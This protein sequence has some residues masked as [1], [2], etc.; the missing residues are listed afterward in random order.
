MS[1][2]KEKLMIIDGNA[3]I[4]RSF[5]ALPPTMQ[6]KDGTVVN[7][8]YGFVTTLL[9]A[10]ND[11]KPDYI[12][13]TFDEKGPTFRHLE[14]TEY[15][16]HR[17]KQ[18]DE[19][20]AQIPLIKQ[21]VEAFNIPIYSQSGLEADDLIGTI[22]HTISNEIEKI[23]LTGDMDTLQLVNDHTKVYAM[24]R[25]I[26]ES[27]I[28]DE[29]K[30]K[31]KYSGLGPDQMIDY[32]ALRGDPSDNI[33]GVKGIG[34]KTAISLLTEFK[35]LD[36]VYEYIEKS[37]E[38]KL[39][40]DK[41][42]KP[43]IIGLLK[44]DK[45]N[46]YLSQKLAT[47]KCD[48]EIDFDLKKSKF[49]K[50]N[51]EELINLLASLEFHSLIPRIKKLAEGENAEII[52]KFERN[53]KLFNYKIIEKETEFI[54]FKKEL[55]GL[56]HFTFDIESNSKNALEADIIGISFSWQADRAYYLVID[57]QNE[58]GKLKEANLFNYTQRK[59]ATINPWL[60]ELKPIFENALIQK[61]GHNIKYDINALSN[62]GINVQ[63]VYFDTRLASYLL[64]PGTRQ[65]GLDSLSF[66]LLGHDKINK[67]D[68]LGA[69][70]DK[71]EF[72]EVETKKIAIYSCED[73]DFTEK[74]IEP[75]TNNLKE[76]K[77]YE[78]F[79][80]IELPLVPILAHMEQAGINIDKKYLAS[81]S[82]DL[83]SRLDIITKKIY[84]VAGVTFNINSTQQLRTVLFEKLA[85][86]VTLIEKTK[87]G[88]STAASELEKLRASHP[89]IIL[90]EE[91][92]ELSKLLNTYIDAL[93]KLINPRTGRI[94]TSLNQ[95][96][97]ATGRLSSQD[98]NL[99]NIPT[100]TELGKSIRE[101]FVANKGYKLLSLDYSQIE[102]RLAAHLSQDPKMIEAF[103]TGQDIHT[104]TASQINN[105]PINEVTSDMRREAKAINFGILYGQ[106][107]RGL[108]KT[109]N[110]SFVRAQEF[111]K[112]Y[113]VVFAKVKDYI[114]TTIK[115]AET[116]G[117]VETIFGRVRYLHDINSNMIQVKK[118]AERMAI[119]T[120]MQGSAADLIKIAMIDVAKYLEDK[121][122]CKMLLQIHDELIFEV[123]ESEVK[124][125]AQALKEIMEKATNNIKLKVPIV[126]DTETGDNWGEL[127]KI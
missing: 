62:Y 16:A 23:I 94:H 78:L 117:Y 107:A 8:V 84:E 14:Y 25:G 92:R 20:Y 71:L 56:K 4:H 38:E 80:K 46:A 100:R 126:V 3:L 86:P 40:E 106:G 32:K 64:N 115:K 63:G 73:A 114:D 90:I 68:L 18:P 87:T 58:K 13:L 47:I 83:N 88:L 74:L 70:K 120:P 116:D 17:E 127:E 59:D 105:V 45:A 76:H 2:K 43:R 93:P 96:I 101:A 1:I 112:N 69:G 57:S 98:P 108:S 111:I 51:T 67:K 15:K 109:A 122:D 82:K 6:T 24:S 52:D 37:S 53:L 34:E 10:I 99:Q 77:L 102:L 50:I 11:M 119:N 26:T 95:T 54:K 61:S 123:A 31:K 7:A 103:E 89:I 39:T 30:K 33:P 110:I 29:A 91:H 19:L 35:S 97:A 36:G 42:I 48:A 21:M 5:H 22:T 72:E 79:T 125:Y 85:L 121:P 118:T 60:I 104:I 44:Q 12:A 28:Y 66:S 65:H 124:K 49:E 27:I 81:L 55:A 75:L 41:L 113:F 9:K